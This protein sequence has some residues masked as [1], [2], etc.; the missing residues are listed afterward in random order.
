MS[1]TLK[2]RD[3]NNS[4][5]RI[6][7]VIEKSRG[8][9]SARVSSEVWADGFDI[10]DLKTPHE[11]QRRVSDFLSAV[12]AELNSIE[13]ALQD[14]EVPDALYVH[15]LS[16]LRNV[17]SVSALNAKW[18]DHAGKQLSAE[19]ITSLQWIAFVLPIEAETTNVEGIAEIVT[20]LD[21]LDEMMAAEGVPPALAALLNKHSRE[22]RHAIQ[23]FPVQGVSGVKKAARVVLVDMKLDEDEVRTAAAQGD[24]QIV[25]TVGNAFKAMFDKTASACGDIDKMHKAS[26][27]FFEVLEAGKNVLGLP[28]P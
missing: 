16:A 7:R 18:D 10:E 19:T 3:Y 9:S 27:V 24:P 2:P 22:I 15:H 11:K 8:K 28:L 14:M 17:F 21:A 13:A 20:L 12:G 26:K 1:R 25:K 6:L 4:A 5:G 23:L